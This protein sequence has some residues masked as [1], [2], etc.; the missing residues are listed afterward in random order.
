[1]TPDAQRLLFAGGYAL[2]ATGFLVFVFMFLGTPGRG[3]AWGPQ[4]IWTCLGVATNAVCG[5]LVILFLEYPGVWVV[6]STG[7]LILL[8][9]PFALIVHL[10]RH[11]NRP[12][13]NGHVQQGA[14]RG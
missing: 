2:M 4:L 6:R 10:V 7:I 14:R 5:A 13:A 3:R 12:P 9:V 1:M 11:R 8:P